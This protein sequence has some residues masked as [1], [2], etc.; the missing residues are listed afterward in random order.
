MMRAGGHAVANWLEKNWPRPVQVV[1]DALHS[2]MDRVWQPQLDLAG[3]VLINVEDRTIAETQRRIGDVTNWHYIL[4]LRDPFNLFASR[5]AY[6]AACQLPRIGP[7]PVDCWRE[8]ARNAMAWNASPPKDGTLILF[9]QWFRSPV[10]R[11]HLAQHFKLKDA[12]SSRFPD[13]GL[14]DVPRRGL[15]SSFD[16]LGYDGKAQQMP[17]LDRW[18]T[19]KPEW[20]AEQFDEDVCLLARF[21]FDSGIDKILGPVDDL[22]RAKTCHG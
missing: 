17:V 11:L 3:D 18:K 19:Q 8:H 5:D 7:E 9:N 4:V 2:M 12:R 16:Q 21:L 1:N 13:A 22:V 15:G 10:Y 20:Y 6:G 14:N